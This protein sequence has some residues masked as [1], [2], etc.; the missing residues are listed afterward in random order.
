MEGKRYSLTNV[1][2]ML[3]FAWIS[4]VEWNGMSGAGGA[5][6]IFYGCSLNPTY[7]STS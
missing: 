5:R 6:V 7:G 4:G 1:D 3:V 2:D